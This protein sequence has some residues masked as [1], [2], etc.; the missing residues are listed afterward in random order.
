ME[1]IGSTIPEYQP[2]QIYGAC[3]AT[4]HD[5]PSFQYQFGYQRIKT[6]IYCR[7]S[8]PA[9]I[10]ISPTNLLIQPYKV[11]KFLHGS[12]FIWYSLFSL[13]T[14]WGPGNFIF[15][16]SFCY[17]HIL[18]LTYDAYH[19]FIDFNQIYTSF[20]PTYVYCT[21]QGLSKYTSVL[22]KNFQPHSRTKA[23]RKLKGV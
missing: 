12:Y 13:H 19:S 7:K 4:V 17:I 5:K 21:S 15:R 16:F 23:Q 6:F 11:R 8:N 10:K 9:L 20:S 14:L 22:E 2:F 18:Q 1:E 3:C